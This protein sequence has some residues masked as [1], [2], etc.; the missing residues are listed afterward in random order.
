MVDKEGRLV[1]NIQDDILNGTTAVHGG[2]YIS[3]RVI[4][5]LKIK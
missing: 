5:M 1:L 4:Q 3:Q 2:E